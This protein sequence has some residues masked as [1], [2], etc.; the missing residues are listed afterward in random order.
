MKNTQG[1]VL[2][3]DADG[4]LLKSWDWII[5]AALRVR[6]Q[7]GLN[8]SE[9]DVTQHFLSGTALYIFYEKF[10]GSAAL[11]EEC[12]KAHRVFQE[13]PESIENINLYPGAKE[14]LERLSVAGVRFGI[15]TSRTNSRLL[16]MTLQKFGMLHL[17][18]TI[19]CLE[20]VTKPKPDPEC[21]HL[22]MS[23][24]GAQ[25][26]LTY[27]VGDTTSDTDAGHAAGIYTIAALYGFGGTKLTASWANAF[28]NSFSEIE[29]IVLEA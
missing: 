9:E 17:F 5:G 7:F 4:T 29:P 23:R 11:A 3:C 18:E 21:L 8:F 22:V 2:I 6:E 25:K 12:I 16:R 24:L 28:I 26:E 27:F 13:L 14:T 19:V 15:A 10:A 1:K 20:D